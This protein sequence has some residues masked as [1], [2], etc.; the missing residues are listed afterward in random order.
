MREKLW[1][2]SHPNDRG[3]AGLSQNNRAVPRSPK[4]RV[5]LPVGRIDK[6]L[7]SV[8]DALVEGPRGTASSLL[9]KKRSTGLDA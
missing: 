8:D 4:E 1:S 5:E 6:G 9:L 7:N 3:F 2:G